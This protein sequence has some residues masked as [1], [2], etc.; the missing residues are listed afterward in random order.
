MSRTWPPHVQGQALPL[1]RRPAP[2]QR[3]IAA[4]LAHRHHAQTRHDRGRGEGGIGVGIGVQDGG[5]AARQQ[6][7]EQPHL[8]G[9]IVLHRA[10]IV[11]VIL[12]QVG[13]GGGLQSDPIQPA[14]V[15]AVGRGLQRDV[16][17][18]LTGQFGHQAGGLGG[19][20][21]GQAGAG[22]GVG[23]VA[24]LTHDAQGAHAGGLMPDAGPQL[25]A[26]GGDRGLA[27]GAGHGHAGLGLGAVEAPR[28]DGVGAAHIAGRDQDRGC[29]F[30]RV[31]GGQDGDGALGQGLGNEGAAVGGRSRQGD[32]QG[33][34]RDL[35]AV[36]G[37]AGDDGIGGHVAAQQV[38]QVKRAHSPSPRHVL[39]F[40]HLFAHGGAPTVLAPFHAQEAGDAVG[41]VL[42]GRR[43]DIGAGLGIGPRLVHHDQYGVAFAVQRAV[44]G[45]D[46]REGA[47]RVAGVVAAADQLVG[48]AG[49]AAHAQAGRIG[50]AARTLDHIAAH[51]VQNGARGLLGDDLLGLDAARPA[52]RRLKGIIRPPLVRAPMAWIIWPG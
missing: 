10:V 49:F 20:G 43:R 30:G 33:A 19:V 15:D 9:A 3:E 26:E 8:G 36:G 17:H 34:G 37:D 38:G 2:D 51:Q 47:E 28:G 23:L 24:L 21:A 1:R 14:L 25:A 4:P 46:R 27:V 22:Q 11:E 18:V 13:E 5:A 48:R 35:A 7:L 12:G 50:E 31:G 40:R 6:G 44:D 29:G 41:D 45:E 42:D 39:I 16:G 52:L 32:E